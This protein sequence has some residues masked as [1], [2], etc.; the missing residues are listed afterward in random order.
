MTSG[1]AG[2]TEAPAADAEKVRK[3]IS[4]IMP[5]MMPRKASLETFLPPITRWN[6]WSISFSIAAIVPSAPPAPAAASAGGAAP[7]S[8]SGT[9]R[10]SLGGSVGSVI[11]LLSTTLTCL[12]WSAHTPSLSRVRRRQRFR[13]LGAAAGRPAA[14][15]GGFRDDLSQ[16]ARLA[17]SA[18]RAD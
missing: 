17:T 16:R 18:D 3:I 10:P 15:V 7:G 14:D 2:P 5:A 1:G 6:V 13:A 4:T 9:T 8:K 12:G 11:V